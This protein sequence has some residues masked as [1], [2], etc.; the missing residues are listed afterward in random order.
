MKELELSVQD[1]YT[2]RNDTREIINAQSNQLDKDS[3][4]KLLEE[5]EINNV[6]EKEI[7]EIIQKINNENNVKELKKESIAE[8]IKK[9]LGRANKNVEAN[10]VD[11]IVNEV[12]EKGVKENDE[13]NEL[14]TT[15]L[16]RLMA[17]Q[18]IELSE[19]DTNEVIT[20]IEKVSVAKKVGKNNIEEEVQNILNQTIGNSNI[21]TNTVNEVVSSMKEES[22]KNR[23]EVMSKEN[24]KNVI[25][26]M[27]NDNNI[28]IDSKKVEKLITEK[29]K[30]KNNLTTSDVNNIIDNVQ[31]IINDEKL[32]IQLTNKAKENT[33][34]EI[35][36]EISKT[37]EKGLKEPKISNLIPD[38]SREE[39]INEIKNMSI[40]VT[41]EKD[42]RKV[43]KDKLRKLD[44]EKIDIITKNIKK[45][46]DASR[47]E[48]MNATKIEE[49]IRKG[50]NKRDSIDRGR[51]VQMHEKFI[52]N[53]YKLKDINDIHEE[54]YGE[55]IY[56]DIRVTLKRIEDLYKY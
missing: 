37:V 38:S 26:S 43:V 49:A 20:I 52:D 40:E 27:A 33:T 6:S 41:N 30:E 31:K 56:K 35:K 21:S 28:T 51:N 45:E 55:P 42:I 53:I 23:N 24:L 34:N 8:E 47:R 46:I 5:K 4:R 14:A 16:K 3:L 36:N 44:N 39:I 29:Q 1:K 54:K 9:E 13:I 18:N 17:E 22:I 12:V 25:N 50:I 15:T 11:K 19:K 10:V 32:N 48:N 2:L 7:E